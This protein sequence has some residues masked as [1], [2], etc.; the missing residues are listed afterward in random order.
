MKL[1]IKNRLG[2][3]TMAI[4][5]IMMLALGSFF[6]NHIVQS[7]SD[8]S[9]CSA[10]GIGMSLTVY[11]ADGITPIGSSTVTAGE[12]VVYRATLNHLGASYC[13][14]EGGTLNITKPN[15]VVSNVTGTGIPLITSGN[16]LVSMPV[17]YVV[18]VADVGSDN[19]LDATATYLGGT[20]HMGANNVSPVSAT[21]GVASN[22]DVQRPF[23]L[24][25]IHNNQHADITGQT[26]VVG[27]VIHDQIIITPTS[28]NNAMA[29]GTVDFLLYN[30]AT[31][32]GQPAMSENNIQLVNGQAESATTTAALYAI[33]YRVH[34]DGNNDYAPMTADCEWLLV[35]Q[36]QTTVTTEIH[37]ANHTNITDGSVVVGTPIHDKVTITPYS[38]ST[39]TPPMASG[40]VDFQVF[41][42]EACIGT[43][44]LYQHNVPL[45]NGTT[46]SNTI[47]AA[48]WWVSYRARY[49]GDSNYPA[50]TADCEVVNVTRPTDRHQVDVASQVHTSGHADVT[51]QSVMVGMPIHDKIMVTSTSTVPTGSVTFNFFTNGTCSGNPLSV[52]NDVALV[53]GMM[54]SATRTPAAGSYS[55]LSNYNGSDSFIE[56]VGVCEP[57]TVTP[58]VQPTVQ[59]P[60]K[61]KGLLR[62]IQVISDRLQGR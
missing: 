26:A 11:R 27:T 5:V 44:A 45:I 10:A 32:A 6:A 29:T 16:P 28:T 41:N 61:A 7:H 20:S 18:T 12:S 24:T 39:T 50:I 52:Q 21:V 58:L 30:N 48:I 42:N 54:E 36:A 37:S 25:Q 13:N 15:G 43:P 53:N 55:Y 49:N 23:I 46:E 51:G 8:P 62:A 22:F 3:Q 17:A 33:S 38:A 47:P 35:N 56:H 1:R 9:N 40:T 31:C 57:I 14:Y 34:Y 59:P 4:A 2:K 60:V 19:D